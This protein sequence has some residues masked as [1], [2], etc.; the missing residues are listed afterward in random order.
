MCHSLSKGTEYFFLR[1]NPA[2][3]V[4]LPM[5]QVRLSPSSTCMGETVDP[6]ILDTP[7][8]ALMCILPV[9]LEH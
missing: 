1:A 6:L 3:P 9:T 2:E 8:I 4:I 5:P 7:G